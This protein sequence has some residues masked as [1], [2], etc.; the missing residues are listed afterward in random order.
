MS[1]APMLVAVVQS[2][3]G[4][5]TNGIPCHG[6]R[7]WAGSPHVVC[8]TLLERWI[9]ITSQARGR[10]TR[11]SVRASLRQCDTKDNVLFYCRVFSGQ[12]F[13][14]HNSDIYNSHICVYER[15]YIKVV[16][17]KDIEN[18]WRSWWY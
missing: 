6:A 11:H 13:G 18:C 10:V 1:C 12:M 14:R 17:N 9:V 4:Q 2:D 7:H 16:N 5:Q 15:E 8:H 3:G